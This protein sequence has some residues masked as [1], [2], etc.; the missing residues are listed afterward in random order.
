MRFLSRLF[1]EGKSRVVPVS[2][3]NANFDQKVLKH[4]GPCLVDVWSYGCPL[5]K[6][7]KHP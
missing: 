3:N 6:K 5:K 7:E 2:L 4:K 1:R